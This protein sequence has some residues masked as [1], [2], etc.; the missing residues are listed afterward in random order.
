M[1]L[2]SV[3]ADCALALSLIGHL[4]REIEIKLFFST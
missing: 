3:S 1:A 2:V 4:F